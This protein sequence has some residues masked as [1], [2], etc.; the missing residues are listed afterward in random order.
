MPGISVEGNLQSKP[1]LCALLKH[2]GSGSGP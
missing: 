1:K 2:R